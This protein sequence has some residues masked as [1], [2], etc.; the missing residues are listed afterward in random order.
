MV[1]RF[2]HG[3]KIFD[4]VTHGPG[5][6]ENSGLLAGMA[7]VQK[8]PDGGRLAGSLL[9][10]KQGL[11]HDLALFFCRRGVKQCQLQLSNTGSSGAGRVHR[12][13]QKSAG[14]SRLRQLLRQLRLDQ[15]LRGSFM[16][17][18][19]VSHCHRY[20]S[21]RLVCSLLPGQYGSGVWRS[22]CPLCGG[23]QLQVVR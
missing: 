6:I 19:P 4:Y 8:L 16:A 3:Q 9:S 12:T 13:D 5:E 17:P 22:H 23:V 14:E 18:Q 15:T 7:R 10:L 21:E 1:R 20:S 11:A 2:R